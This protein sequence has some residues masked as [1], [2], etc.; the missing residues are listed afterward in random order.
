MRLRSVM[1]L[2]IAS[3]PLFFPSLSRADATDSFRVWGGGGYISTGTAGERFRGGKLIGGIRFPSLTTDRQS[4]RASIS[5]SLDS[6]P[7]DRYSLL[8]HVGYRVAD[9]LEIA[10]LG[11]VGVLYRPSNHGTYLKPLIGAEIVSL[12][13]TRGGSTLSAYLSYEVFQGSTGSIALDGGTEDLAAKTVSIGIVLSFSL[14]HDSG[15]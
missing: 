7:T 9:P 10:L 5:R 14:F 12:L 1:L 3:I 8:A 13:A 2:G 6:S 4:I 15:G 11:G